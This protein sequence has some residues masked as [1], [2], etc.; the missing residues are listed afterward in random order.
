MFKYSKRMTTGIVIKKVGNHWYPDIYHYFPEDLVLDE[1][2]EKVLSLIDKYNYGIVTLYIFEQYEILGNGTLQFDESDMVKYLTTDEDLDVKFYIND[3]E[4]KI[5]S[6]LLALLE[7]QFKFD[8]QGNVYR[9][10]I[11]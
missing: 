7:S 11:W 9:I 3:H 1:K 2:I 6:S 10:D 4:Y 5:S 8:F